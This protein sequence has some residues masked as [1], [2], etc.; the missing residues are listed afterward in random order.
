ME[1]VYRGRLARLLLVVAALLCTTVFP[2][3]ASA[4][5]PSTEDA[6]TYFERGVD[7][8]RNS[9][10]REARILFQR[11][12]ELVAK[13]STLYNLAQT[14]LRLGNGAEALERLT[15]FEQAADKNE[16]REMLAR[17]PVLRTQ[18]QTLIDSEQSASQGN[19]SLAPDRPQVDDGLTAQARSY[20][21]RGRKEYA[22]GNDKLALTLFEHAYQASQKPELLYNVA[23]VADRMREDERALQAY[24]AFATAL[25]DAPETAVAQVRS[26]ALRAAIE[27]REQARRAS[28]AAAAASPPRDPPKPVSLMGPRLMVASGVL[29]AA[30]TGGVIGWLV[31]RIGAVNTCDRLPCRPEEDAKITRQYRAALATTIISAGLTVGVTTG[32]IRWLRRRKHEARTRAAQLELRPHLVFERTSR[33]GLGHAGIELGGTF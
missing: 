19:R 12:L 13:P 11:S 9:R 29:L 31:D 30:G 2:S 28:E 23:I 26:T 7:A 17:V 25:P 18:A 6:R 21:A 22:R 5:P 10:W 20:V 27:Q 14:E 24:E 15:A 32:G 1:V 33:T 4:Q 3:L 8:Y 16:H